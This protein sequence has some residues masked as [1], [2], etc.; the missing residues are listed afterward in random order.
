M[1]I[2]C[3]ASRS[4]VGISYCLEGPADFM[5]IGL[6]FKNKLGVV[7]DRFGEGGLAGSGCLVPPGVV[8]LDSLPRTG[9]DA[10]AD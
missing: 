6:L 3:D 4:L 9:D 1:G 8:G 10:S 5:L 7:L 2:T